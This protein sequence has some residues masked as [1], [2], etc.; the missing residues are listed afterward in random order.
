MRYTKRFVLIISALILLLGTMAVTAS[1]QSRAR[2]IYR[3]VFVRHYWGYDPFRSWGY[4]P[5]LYDPY[6][7]EQRDRY[8]KEKAVRDA[9]KKLTKDRDKY[10]AD[11][12]ITAKEQENLAKRRH[13]YEKA[14]TKLNKFNQER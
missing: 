3:P 8:Y 4:D 12:V 14:V 5:Y 13:D 6:L 7:R 1:S 10:R 2:R 11:G 9:N